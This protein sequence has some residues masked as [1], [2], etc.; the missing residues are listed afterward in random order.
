MKVIL[1][2]LLFVIIV[3]RMCNMSYQMSARKEEPRPAEQECWNFDLDNNHKGRILAFSGKLAAGKDSC[4]RLLYSL[5]FMHV[6]NLTPQAEVN[7]STGKLWLEDTEGFHEFNEDARDPECIA[8]MQTR[9]WPFIRKF[10]TADPL[11]EFLHKMFEVPTSSLWGT[12]EEKLAPITH[13]S[14]EDMPGDP[15]QKL[16]FNG[17]K[18]KDMHGNINGRHLMEYYGTEIIRKT[19]TRAHAK[20]LLK[21]IQEWN[22]QYSLVNDIRFIDECE[23]I[24]AVGGKIIRLT[25]CSPEAKK[26]K[27]KSNIE[28]D[29]YDKFNATI[30]NANMTM[31]ET[32][33]ELVR[34]L[35]EWEYFKVVNQ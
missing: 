24:H 15:E 23:E 28:L 31:T 26:N 1:V 25:R 35:T 34:V 17:K 13:L 11:K 14:W 10:S 18:L 32:F 20:A 9:V 8:F 19:Y 30:D 33:V 4:C 7:E 12:Q 21:S 6:L 2:G 29:S 3:E 5:A 16:E 22:S 27:H